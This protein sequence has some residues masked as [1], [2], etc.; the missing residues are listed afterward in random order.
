[1]PQNYSTFLRTVKEGILGSFRDG[2]IKRRYLKETGLTDTLL[3]LERRRLEPIDIA[4]EVLLKSHVEVPEFNGRTCLVMLNELAKFYQRH[5][6]DHDMKSFIIEYSR[7]Q[8]C[9]TTIRQFLTSWF[10]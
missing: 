7:Q 9:E 6:A 1:M 3:D 10:N 2:S 8:P 5:V 4:L